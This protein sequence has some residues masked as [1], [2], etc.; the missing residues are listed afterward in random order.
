[1]LNVI[2]YVLKTCGTDMDSLIKTEEFKNLVLAETVKTADLDSRSEK[3]I[4][5]KVGHLHFGSLINRMSEKA[6]I[7]KARKTV[8]VEVRSAEER[9]LIRLC[10]QMIVSEAE[11]CLPEHVRQM[12]MR[13]TTVSAEEQIKMI[14]ELYVEFRS[15]RQLSKGELSTAL[16]KEKME[17]KNRERRNDNESRAFLP[18][19]YKVWNKE[20]NPAN[21]QGK[22][23]ML[24]AFAKLAGAKVMAIHP[25]EHAAEYVK[26]K[27]RGIRAEVIRDLEQRDLMDGSA[28]FA[29]GLAASRYDDMM[30]DADAECFHVG[31]IIELKDGRWMMCDPH[32]LSRGL[33]SEK[34][35]M[36]KVC[37]VLNKYR[38]VLPGL[39]V[40]AGDIL[41]NRE[42][43]DAITAKSYE[44]IERSRK[45]EQRIKEEVETVLDLARV[46][47]SSDDLDLLFNMELKGAVDLTKPEI[48][49]MVSQQVAVGM[50]FPGIGELMNPDFLK[51]R[52]KNWLTFYH[53][54]AINNFIHQ[55]AE[56]EDLVHPMCEVSAD[57]EWSIA[58]SAINSARFDCGLL[59][60]ETETFFLGHSFDQTSLYNAMGHFGSPMAFAAQQTVRSL[61]YVHPMCTRRLKN[62][63]RWW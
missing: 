11:K 20:N 56:G 3:A 9:A 44:I 2:R 31:V 54:C 7:E 57:T 30:R 37:K 39:T 5:L 21:C 17:C 63:E 16:M 32:G 15:N 46:I 40:M 58:I 42:M 60:D 53:T 62:I 41:A 1:M 34:W 23:Q 13:W 14:E 43:I 27:M 19:L 25:V 12:A 55:K 28:E 22:T 29:D 49:E 48:R 35:E 33:I 6:A 61:R 4:A 59:N 8:V 24:T 45:M 51:K 26:T 36:Q 10:G 47:C 50:E 52:V 38:D 18:G